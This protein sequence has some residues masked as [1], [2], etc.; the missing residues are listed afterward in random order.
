[1]TR[2][3]LV[4]GWINVIISVVALVAYIGLPYLIYDQLRQTLVLR[5]QSELLEQY[6]N[7]RIPIYMRFY[8]FNVLNPESVEFEGAKPIIRE[9]GPYT[10][11]QTRKKTVFQ[12]T[13]NGQ[14]VVFKERKAYYFDP[15]RS[16]GGLNDSLSLP[17]IPKLLLAN[18]AINPGDDNEMGGLFWD[19]FD[20][21]FKK[22]DSPLFDNYTVGQILFQGFKSELLEE[23]VTMLKGFEMEVPKEMEDGKFGLQY[24]VSVWH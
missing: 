6:A 18:Q 13:E 5:E 22:F 11:R 10:F 4:I 21:T 3:Q 23:T 8:F 16:I 19:I 20:A 12:F 14:Q 24:K 9:Q 15:Q 7:V 2:R 1:M 17:N